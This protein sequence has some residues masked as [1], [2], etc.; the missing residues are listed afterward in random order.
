M[1]IKQKELEQNKIITVKQN[2]LDQ[3]NNNH[4][5][6]HKR[7]LI[8]Q[9]KIKRNLNKSKKKQG[10]QNNITHNDYEEQTEGT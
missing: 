1:K 7:N 8:K 6:K 4:E 9:M 3:N 5:D 10:H 2:E